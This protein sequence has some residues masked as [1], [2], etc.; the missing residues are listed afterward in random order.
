MTL[1]SLAQA[2]ALTCLAVPAL[3]APFD[4]VIEPRAI[5]DLASSEK[6]LITAVNVR[7][8]DRITEGQVLV[9][10]D[11]TVQRLQVQM[12]AT[13]SASDVEVRAAEARREQ[14]LRDVDRAK[15]LAARNVAT[16]TQVE[17]AEIEL[18]LTELSLEQARLTQALA[19]IE[20]QQAEALLDRRTIRSPADGIVLSVV[21]SPGAF[22]AEQRTL[23]TLA[24]IDPLFVEV[25]VPPEYF[26]RV[27]V[28]NVYAV[29]QVPPLTGQ[30]E[31]SVMVVDQVFDAASG[32]FG[33]RLQIANP[34]GAIPAGTRCLVDLD[35]SLN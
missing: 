8:G 16:E 18:A 6:G 27:A 17:T 11:D 4:C 2:A 31:A 30:F 14:R 7:R 13:R 1:R 29:S 21:A 26:D 35:A 9:K 15:T 19:A 20:L 32:T 34:D 25:F 24:R 23:L 12:T 28:G 33:L 5:V 10:L 22:A 3:S